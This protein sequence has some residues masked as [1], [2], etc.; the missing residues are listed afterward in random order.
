MM[1]VDKNKIAKEDIL[2]KEIKNYIKRPD[3]DIPNLD[4]ILKSADEDKHLNDSSRKNVYTFKVRQWLN[5]NYDSDGN[6]FTKSPSGS[7][8]Y[9]GS[10]SDSDDVPFEG[11]KSRRRSRHSRRSNKKSR[12]GRKIRKSRRRSRHVRS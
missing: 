9:F 3:G 6:R 11:G 1:I 12:K 7:L 8:D 5:Q 2:V 4:S 10:D